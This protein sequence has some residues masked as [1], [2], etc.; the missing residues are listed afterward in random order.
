MDGI[1]NCSFIKNVPQ[2]IQMVLIL[3]PFSLLVDFSVD[4]AMRM[5]TV[6]RQSS[7]FCH[8]CSS[9]IITN[10]MKCGEYYFSYPCLHCLPFTLHI[11]RWDKILF[12]VEDIIHHSLTV[13]NL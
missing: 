10:K 7:W 13:K 4:E 1:H 6:R 9:Y 8:L 12:L 2:R 3:P 5:V 11:S